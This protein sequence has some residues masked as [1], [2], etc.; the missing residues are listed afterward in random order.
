MLKYLIP[1][2]ILGLTC[3][4]SDPKE[5]DGAYE[6][7]LG[8]FDVVTSG[9]GTIDYPPFPESDIPKSYAMVLSSEL[10]QAKA[11]DKDLSEVGREAGEWLLL[12]ITKDKYR[13]WGLPVEWDAFG[14]GTVNSK[15][16]IYTITTA[17]VVEAL[18]N[19]YESEF[20]A[21]KE[22]ILIIVKDVLEPF[23]KDKINSLAGIYA[24]SD[25]ESDA[26]YDCFNPAGYLLGQVQRFAK[27]SGNADYAASADKNVAIFLKH[28]K[29]S[30][31]GAWYWNYSVSENNPNDMPHA[32]YIYLGLREY[33][34]HGGSLSAQIDLR[35]V[36]AHYADF[37]SFW[38]GWHA[39]PVF[40]K[41]DENP[42]PRLYDLG[43]ALYAMSTSNNNVLSDYADELF[44]LSRKYKG[45][46]GRYYYRPD[47]R[48]IINEYNAYIL[49]G[50]AGLRWGNNKTINWINY[51]G[52]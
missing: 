23:I 15:S 3:C 13:G 21:P 40:M 22:Q 8:K 12:N 10:I 48:K 52:T 9:R 5:I 49:L 39:W 4:K 6:G 35:K 41:L 7:L 50:F 34:K 28:K 2:F 30:P 33:V 11:N 26:K 44:R 42:K 31:S 16:T 38:R 19:W 51:D 43:I 27:I 24:Y 1:I 32:T 45:D 25:A 18:L 20:A 17:I 29:L 36:E 47:V 46:D 37:R 14:D